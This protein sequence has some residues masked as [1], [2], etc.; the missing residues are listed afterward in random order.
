MAT[1]KRN[2]SVQL[3]LDGK[4]IY[5]H[6]IKIN[7]SVKREDKDMSGQK[8]STKKTDKGVKAKELNVIG[9]IPYDRKE[10]LTNLFNL[11]EAENEKGEQVTYRVS[12]LIAEAI[13]M[14]EVQFTGTVNAT[15]MGGRLA[16]SVSFTLREVNSIAEKKEQ[17]KPKPKAKT[18]GE[19]APVAEP[20]KPV[21]E[22][23]AEEKPKEEDN[24]IWKQ[25]DD[26]LGG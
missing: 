24:S 8:S 16:W 2:P 5:L 15:E 6:D 1:I 23:K 19:S 25:I 10:W 11:A 20:S 21:A 14:R 4:P 9:V 18:Q 22:P 7:A 12:C 17:R 13:N 26:A 3:A